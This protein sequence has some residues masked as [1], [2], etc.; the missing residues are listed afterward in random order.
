MYAWVVCSNYFSLRLN[1]YKQKNKKAKTK[2]RSKPKVYIIIPSFSHTITRIF[3]A[4][5]STRETEMENIK[6]RH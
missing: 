2:K 4:R 6:K 5:K 3:K 1:T